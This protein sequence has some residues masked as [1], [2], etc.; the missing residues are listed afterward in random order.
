[1][2][3][4]RWQLVALRIG[5]LDGESLGSSPRQGR[6]VALCCDFEKDN[7]LSQCLPLNA[8]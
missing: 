5:D 1:M 4:V 2:W 3:K 6:C 8:L 7:F